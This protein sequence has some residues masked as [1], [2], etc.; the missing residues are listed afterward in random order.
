MKKLAPLSAALLMSFMAAPSF[1]AQA[2]EQYTQC[3]YKKVAGAPWAG[4]YRYTQLSGHV[5]CPANLAVTIGYYKLIS[6]RHIN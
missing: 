4:E 2:A 5:T 1:D 3:T 6:Q